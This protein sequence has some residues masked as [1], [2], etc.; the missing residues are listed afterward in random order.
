[1]LYFLTIPDQLSTGVETKFF[2]VGLSE[3]GAKSAP[4]SLDEA[5]AGGGEMA[6]VMASCLNAS[7]CKFT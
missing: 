1:L 3:P 7:D 4:A 2:T 5:M 6:L